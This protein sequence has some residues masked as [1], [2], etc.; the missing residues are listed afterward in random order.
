MTD[1]NLT[2]DQIKKV[3]SDLTFSMLGLDPTN[4]AGKVR[5]EWPTTGSPGWK[6][7]DDI[8]FF[9]IN[10]DDDPI[11]R[12]MDVTYSSL[13]DINLN[14]SLSYTRVIRVNWMCYG[15]NSFNNIDIIRSSLSQPDFISTLKSNNIALIMDLSMPTRAPELFNGQWWDRSSLYAR[16]NELVVRS[17][18]VPYIQTPNIQVIKG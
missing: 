10:F 7:T 6:I 14:Q 12:Q 15:P 16:F 13:D 8:T 1:I 2:L 4:D 3:F 17:T 11:T 5:S 9:A 18:P